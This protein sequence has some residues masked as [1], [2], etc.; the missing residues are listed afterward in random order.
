MQITLNIGDN[1]NASDLTTS[2]LSN[3]AAREK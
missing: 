1:L 3:S 2:S